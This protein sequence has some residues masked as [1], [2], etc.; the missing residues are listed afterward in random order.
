MALPQT[1][2]AIV[3][4]R[5]TLGIRRSSFQLC[6]AAFADHAMATAQIGEDRLVPLVAQFST[7][8]ASG[9]RGTVAANHRSGFLNPIMD[10]GTRDQTM[11]TGHL[12]FAAFPGE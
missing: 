2:V 11:A 9:F 12:P 1:A 5:M 3:S 4:L 6:V 10:S 8:R 7:T